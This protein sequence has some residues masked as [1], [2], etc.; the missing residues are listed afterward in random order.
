MTAGCPLIK[1]FVDGM[2]FTMTHGCG[3]EGGTVNGHPATVT[4]SV[5]IS[6]GLPLNNTRVF[7][8]GDATG[9]W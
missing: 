3:F 8:V 5:A 4:M 7:V 9:A 2:S 1:T 6:A